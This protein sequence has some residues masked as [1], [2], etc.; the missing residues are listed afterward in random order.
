M[1]AENVNPLRNF[2]NIV[3]NQSLDFDSKVDELLRFGLDLF[4]LEVGIVSQIVGNDY[5]VFR[6][7]NNIDGL[8]AGMHFDLGIT[9]C[10]YTINVKEVVG[11]H[12]VGFSNI[13]SHPCYEAQKLEAYLAAPIIIDNRVFGTINFS[14]AKP[15]NIFEPE[16]Y[17]FIELFAQWLGSEIAKRQV[18]E[19]L[20]TK[21]SSLA[22]L[23]KVAKVG[24]WSVDLETN[25]VLWSDQ[26]KRIHEAPPG[27][28][29]TFESAVDFYVVGTSRDSISHA[30]ELAI[31]TGQSWDLKTQ[32]TTMK[33]H[34][35]WVVSKGEAEFFENKC[36]KLFGT[37]QDVTDSEEASR[38]LQEAKYKA[39]QA[40]KAKSD[41]LANMSHEIRTPMNGVLGTLQLLERSN[42]D[43]ESQMLI[44]RASFSATSL[45]TIINDILDY[46]KIE[47]NQLTLEKQPFSMCDVIE[48][49]HSELSLEAAEKQ[50]ALKSS[51]SKDFVDGWKGDVVRV[52]QILLNLCAN[53]VK[54]TKSGQV[55]I[56][57]MNDS[58]YAS[59]ALRFTVKDTGI[60]MSEEE[61]LR[62]IERFTQ[63]DSSTTRKFGGTGLGMSITVSLVE[64]MGGKI[65]VD[66]VPNQGTTITVTLP[67]EHANLDGKKTA[68][69][70][71]DVPNLSGKTILIA[72]DND[73]NTLVIESMLAATQADLQ[74]AKNGVEA[75]EQ[76]S[77]N[78]PDLVLMDIQMPEMDGLQAF[79]EIQKLNMSVP[80]IALTANVMS[81][82]I[83]HYARV[84]FNAYLAKPVKLTVLYDLLR[85]VLTV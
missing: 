49:V 30:V 7:V 62:V 33:G 69:Q 40:T 21:A 66:S 77:K 27:Y 45:L 14:A 80:V 2:H 79:A 34:R 25:H 28:Q 55:S 32:I 61:Q 10:H 64:M 52:R 3:S 19:Q 82:D 51:T 13:A 70:T 17:E 31:K 74:F 18:L 67:L 83:E 73:I 1:R 84:G 78:I 29:P 63:A 85:S 16:S 75:L 56:A 68:F 54:F 58:S 60:G 6:T 71:D 24:S 41:F 57:L 81:T 5:K 23:E 26:T 9:Y 59:G 36:I 8:D 44:S 11:F 39:E 72:E 35:R 50:I 65:E 53:A 46:S 12:H 20:R 4:G 22:K 42:L 47:A 48:H 38:K 15:V 43:S 76:F 37:F